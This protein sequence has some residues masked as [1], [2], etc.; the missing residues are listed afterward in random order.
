[1]PHQSAVGLTGPDAYRTLKEITMMGAVLAPSK[2]ADTGCRESHVSSTARLQ[3]ARWLLPDPPPT[4][5]ELDAFFSAHE[6]KVCSVGVVLAASC[7]HHHRLLPGSKRDGALS[8][9]DKANSVAMNY[10]LLACTWG[11]HP[12]C[13][14]ASP[15]CA[16]RGSRR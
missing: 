12:V 4:P 2:V 14:K 9:S 10:L 5:Q 11:A 16:C 15:T 8:H 7:T 3:S 13:R 1:M 6:A